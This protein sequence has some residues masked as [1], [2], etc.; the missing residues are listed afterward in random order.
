[1]LWLEASNIEARSVDIDALLTQLISNGK[2]MELIKSSVDADS[3]P[4]YFA[5][6]F[7]E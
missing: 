2:T 3:V 7:Q 6:L 1:M 5:C 4:R